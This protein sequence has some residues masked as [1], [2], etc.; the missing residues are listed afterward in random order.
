MAG[1]RFPPIVIE[2]NGAS[3]PWDASAAW[4]FQPRSYRNPA[5]IAFHWLSYSKMAKTSLNDIALPRTT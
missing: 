3:L 4:G 5:V 2:M 1:V